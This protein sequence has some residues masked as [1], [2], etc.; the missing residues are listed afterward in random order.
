MSMRTVNTTLLALLVLQWLSGLG[1]YFVGS[2]G[3]RWVVWAHAVG[4]MAI[5]VLLG[6][7]GG[8]ILDSLSR[9]GLGWWAA[10]SLLLLA[11]LLLVLVSGLWWSL[12]RPPD[13]AGY[14]LLT[15]H[16]ILSLLMAGLLF[17]HAGKLRP[18]ARP[19]DYLRRRGLSRRAALLGGGA[20]AWGLAEVGSL[21]LALPGAERRFTGSYEVEGSG[22]NFPRTAWLFD[23]PDPIDIDRWR[24]QVDGLVERSASFP[25]AA[26]GEST[27]LE[28]VLDCTGGWYA[29]RTWQGVP[30]R[31]LLDDA[32]PR[33]GACSIV[34]TGVTG[35][36]RRFSLATARRA[37]LATHVADEPL[38]HGHGA[39]LRLVVP[40]RRGFDWVKWVVRVEVSTVPAWWNWPLP[41]R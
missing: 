10:P 5:A 28:A 12:A 35:Y 13:L 1:S 29:R 41:L 34:V 15:A 26:L 32:G 3:S 33:P 20:A 21:A 27:S 16:V 6:W 31:R 30:L 36:S 40:G 19:R 25:T 24:L 7:K 22:Q 4:G 39:P 17:P 18:T 9:Q 14:S 11:L 37:L 23:D 2:E 38:T 8:V